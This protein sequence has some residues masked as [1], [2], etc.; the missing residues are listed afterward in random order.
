MS[1]SVL[2]YQEFL[3]EKKA[4]DQEL[5][6]GAPAKGSK[7]TKQVADKAVDLPKG[8]GKNITKSVKP[9]MANLPKGKGTAPKK[10][11]DEKTAKLPT[12]KGTAPKKQVD[13]KLAKLTIT[14]KAINKKVE[15]GMA[16]LKK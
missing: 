1:K 3:L 5:S 6:K 11:V 2:N 14:G 7:I 4:I 10:T 16:K 12:A 8:K 15:P 13:T 9:E